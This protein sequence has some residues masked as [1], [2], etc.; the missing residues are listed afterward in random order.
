[1]RVADDELDAP[2][3]AP[4]Q[5][6][7]ELKPKLPVLARADVQPDHLP[8]PGQTDPDRDHDRL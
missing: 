2:Q 6:A 8:L 1:M 7:Q 4:N 3:P 5:A